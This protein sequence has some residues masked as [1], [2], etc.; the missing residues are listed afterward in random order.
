MTGGNWGRTNDPDTD[1]TSLA[2]IVKD[3]G[4]VSHGKVDKGDCPPG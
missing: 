2:Y 4:D 1:M 3:C